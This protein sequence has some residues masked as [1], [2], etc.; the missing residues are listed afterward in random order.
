MSKFNEDAYEYQC[1][2]WL[3]GI[4]WSWVKGP[5]IAHDGLNPERSS[6][7]DVVLAERLMGALARINPNIP[8]E[9][10][11]KVAQSLISPGEK[12]LLKANQVIHSWMTEGYPI[13]VRKDSGEETTE[14]AW[15]IDFDN[16]E[17]NDWVAVNQ[18]SV[19]V[20]SESGTRRP[21]IVLF[22]NGIPVSV[23]E[24]KNPAD[25][26]TDIW[27]SISEVLCVANLELIVF[28][29]AGTETVLRAVGFVGKNEYVS[30]LSESGELL[31]ITLRRKLLN[32]GKNYSTNRTS[33]NFIPQVLT[34]IGLLWILTH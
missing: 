15:L 33:G 17:N 26:D 20:D 23:I 12:D 9:S 13:K 16:I 24:L 25:L 5:E 8:A 1:L 6:H 27:Q 19:Q 22:L 10:L 32:R 2:E 31:F 7:K 28:V 3:Q 21:D 34:R 18:F 11:S 14:L 29:N 30:T 4:G